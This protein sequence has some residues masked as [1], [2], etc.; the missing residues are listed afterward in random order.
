MVPFDKV[1]RLLIFH[2]DHIYRERERERGEKRRETFPS[3]TLISNLTTE[4]QF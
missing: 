3:D 2:P 1:A 4:H